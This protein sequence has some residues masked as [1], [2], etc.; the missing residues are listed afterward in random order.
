[1]KTQEW[2]PFALVSNYET[3][4]IAVN[5]IKVISSSSKMSRCFCQ[6]LTKSGVWIF[7]EISNMKFY[8]N[9]SSESKADAC[10]QADGGAN[11]KKLKVVF[12]PLCHRA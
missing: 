3:F 8:E 11:I 6:I 12:R 10:G 9:P 4:L 2:V 1:M 7:V 5:N